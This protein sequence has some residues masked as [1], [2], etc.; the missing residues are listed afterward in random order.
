[1]QLYA[2]EVR[3]ASLFIAQQQI[4]QQRE[5]VVVDLLVNQRPAQ[6][7]DAIRNDLIIGTS[8]RKVSTAS[9][10]FISHFS[11][12]L[13]RLISPAFTN[14]VR[15]RGAQRSIVGSKCKND[16]GRALPFRAL[17]TRMRRFVEKFWLS[18]K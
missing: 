4:I 1:M 6:F 8:G 14:L 17:S 18:H 11:L 7:L 9:I 12:N 10:L 2:S 16:A 15:I 5:F 3:L 13:L